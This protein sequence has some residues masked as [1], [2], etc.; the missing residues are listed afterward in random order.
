VMKESES[1]LP[2]PAVGRR[3]EPEPLVERAQRPA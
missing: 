1:L 2:W 3:V